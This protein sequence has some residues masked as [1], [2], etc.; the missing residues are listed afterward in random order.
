MFFSFTTLTTT[1]FGN[2]VP[3]G[4]GVQSVAVAE[5][6]TGQLFL[7]T[8]VARIMRGARKPADIAPPDPR[9]TRPMKDAS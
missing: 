9:S 8:A 7:I 6:I 4:P 1:G 2:I 5:A 3:V